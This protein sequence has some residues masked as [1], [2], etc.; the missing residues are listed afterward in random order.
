M[1]WSA[2]SPD[3][4]AIE[5]LASRELKGAEGSASEAA[6]VGVVVPVA[7][8]SELHPLWFAIDNAHTATRAESVNRFMNL[9]SQARMND[10]LPSIAAHD[11]QVGQHPIRL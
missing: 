5:S 8:R 10:S 7:S 4:D 9:R 1:G 6:S 3:D 2:A 11:Q